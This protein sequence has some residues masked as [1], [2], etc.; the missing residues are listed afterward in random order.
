MSQVEPIGPPV[1][2]PAFPPEAPPEPEAPAPLAPDAGFDLLPK[3]WQDE[4][5]E[6]RDAEARYRTQLRE[7]EAI[8][9]GYTDPDQKAMMKE[10]ARLMP[11]AERGDT[12]A[13]ARIQEMLAPEE[14]PGDAPLTRAEIEALVAERATSEAQRVLDERDA[15][16]AQATAISQIEAEVTKR[17]YT[18]QSEEHVLFL[19]AANN[20]VNRDPDA[21]FYAEGEKAVKEYH[22]KIVADY[23]ASKAAKTDGSLRQAN[24]TGTAPSTATNPDKPWEGS[25]LDPIAFARKSANERF[26]K[27][28]G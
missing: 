21:D 17:G 6:K 7:E 19:R 25:G 24:G 16:Q 2:A 14:E 28:R 11:A 15:T 5:K 13:I 10:Y 26:E 3:H 18:L 4:I 9:E 27:M 8:W 1:A 22:Q 20:A 23:L 12:A